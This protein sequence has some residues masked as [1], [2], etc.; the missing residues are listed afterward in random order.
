MRHWPIWACARTLPACANLTQMASAPSQSPRAAAAP[1]STNC[2]DGLLRLSAAAEEVEAEG[3][4]RNMR[5]LRRTAV[6]LQLRQL[7]EEAG[8]VIKTPHVEEKC[9][10]LDVA[11]NRHG[12]AAKS[13]GERVETGSGTLARHGPDGDGGTW[14]GFQWQGA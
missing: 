2:S 8:L 12:K 4:R 10:I 9:S 6:I 5:S 11:D 13:R 3:L 7:G 14:Q 1:A